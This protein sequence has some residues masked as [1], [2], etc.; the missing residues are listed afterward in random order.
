MTLSMALMLTPS[1]AAADVITSVQFGSPYG[2]TKLN[3]P[4]SSDVFNYNLG[5]FPSYMF[6]DSI[7][8]DATTDDPNAVVCWSYMPGGLDNVL[9]GGYIPVDV[10][11]GSTTTIYLTPAVI[12]QSGQL[13]SSSDTYTFNVI[14][15]PDSWVDGDFSL[16]SLVVD[17]SVPETYYT[18]EFGYTYGISVDP[19]AS[20]VAITPTADDSQATITV[21]GIPVVSGES[22]NISLTDFP[23]TVVEIDV[24]AWDGTVGYYWLEVW[25]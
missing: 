4:F 25:R 12:D 14:N 9:S 17:G 11:W 6:A 3:Q 13:V 10:T 7:T 15:S 24:T 20:S 23:R 21:N 2:T 19:N 16:S 1:N 22:I 18:P 8:V 5:L